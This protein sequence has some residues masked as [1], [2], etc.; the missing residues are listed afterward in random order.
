MEIVISVILGV[1][2]MLAGILCLSSYKKD[3]AQYINNNGKE[4]KNK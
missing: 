1:W 4:E 3:V 2:I